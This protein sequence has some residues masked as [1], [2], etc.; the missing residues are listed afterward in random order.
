V[1]VATARGARVHAC[2]ET[3]GREV[4][5]RTGAELAGHRGSDTRYSLSPC[6]LLGIAEGTH[7]VL[8][9]LNGS[10]LSSQVGAV[11]TLAGCLRNAEAVARAAAGQGTRI[12]VIPAGER[13][14][15]GSLRPCVEDWLGAGAILSH[16]S[17]SLSPEARLARA[18]FQESRAEL[19]RM[20]RESGSG[21]ELRE[22][23][24]GE[25]VTLAA[26]LDA[27]ATAPR[28]EDGAYVA[29][30]ALAHAEPDALEIRPYRE[31]D[32]AGVVVLWDVVFPDSQPH[33]APIPNIERKLRVQRDLFL[34]ARL[35]GRVVGSVM[36]GFDGHRGWVYYLASLPELR[37]RGI[38]RALMEAAEQAL[39][40][41]GCTKLNLQ[42]RDTNLGVIAFYE[43]LGYA[44]EERASLAKRLV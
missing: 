36:A 42:V 31:S 16:L 6:S 14:P 37:G 35:E 12:S 2:D 44:L 34:V 1:D 38:G 17:G 27:S 26:Q 24:F 29:G 18:A 30:D 4:A 9:S 10:A 39:R 23:G 33:N 15:D 13:W 5:E 7:L 19:D 20:L 22:R 3:A 41:R 43:K 25:D 8:P 28:L 40:R 11:P 32:Q 21:R